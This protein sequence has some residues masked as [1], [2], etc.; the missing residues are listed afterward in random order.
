[1]LPTAGRPVAVTIAVV[2]ALVIAAQSVWIRHGMETGW[3]DTAVDAHLRAD[4]S[5]HPLL[6]DVLIWPGEPLPTAAMTG[7][8]VL[9]C[10]L[11][12]RYRQAVLVAVSVPLAAALTELVLKPLIGWTSWGNPFPSGHITNVA[13]L[14]TALTVLVART[15]TRMAPLVWV[16]LGFTA[17]LITAGVAAGVIGANMHHF[18]DTAGGP[19]SARGRCWRP[20]SSS[21]SSVGRIPSAQS[22]DHAAWWICSGFGPAALRG[23]PGS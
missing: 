16:A 7:T 12:R 5:G 6:L 23:Q 13:A 21:T 1:M 3:L 19:P 2:C 22:E 10:A 9:A 17:L 4:L 8:L 11:R 18:S 14:V 15:A 20:R